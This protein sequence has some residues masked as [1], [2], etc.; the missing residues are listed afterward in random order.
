MS[1]SMLVRRSPDLTCSCEHNR[2][3]EGFAFDDFGARA[4]IYRR[5]PRSNRMDTMQSSGEDKIFV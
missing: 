2:H 1:A 4:R 3:L 5:Q